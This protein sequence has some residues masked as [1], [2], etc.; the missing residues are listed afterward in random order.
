[1]NEWAA[2]ID[3]AL[4]GYRLSAPVRA[5]SL[6][7]LSENATYVVDL[8]DDSTVVVRLHRPGFRSPREIR[9]ELSWITALRCEDVV[10]TPAIIPDGVG[11]NLHQFTVQGQDRYAV[12]FEFVEGSSPTIDDDAALIDNFANIGVISRQLHNHVRTWSPP[13][14]FTRVT[15]SPEYILGLKNPSWEPWRQNPEVT[16]QTAERLEEVEAHALVTLHRYRMRHPDRFGLIHT[17][18]RTTN[19]IVHQGHTT[20]LDF[21][22]C[23]FGFPMWDLAG[24]LSFIEAEAVVP[25]LVAAWLRGYGGVDADDLATIP[26]LIIMRRLQLVGWMNTRQ[27]TPEHEQMVGVYV[28]ETERIGA[29]F[30]RGTYALTDAGVRLRPAVI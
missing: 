21:D 17:D 26:A 28:P 15:W 19:L 3:E 7:S 23:G 16:R 9:S 4:A 10:R 13:Q 18:L 8:A 12:M 25:H 5:T 24:A 2:S 6:V 14:D 1:M 22:D 11:Q 27:G 30:L 20:I 29:D